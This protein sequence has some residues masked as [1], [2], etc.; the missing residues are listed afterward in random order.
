MFKLN[1]IHA[2]LSTPFNYEGELYRAKIRHNVEKWNRVALAGYVVGGAAGEGASLHDEERALL[3]EEVAGHAAPGRLLIAG[4]GRES[5]RETVRS[6]NRAAELGYG[7]ALIETPL[8][9]PELRE[10]AAAQALY[11][12]AVADQ[13]KIPV[14]VRNRPRETG[15]DLAVETAAALSE[16]PNLAGIVE[17][18][19][20]AGKL[21]RLIAAMRP[22]LAVLTGS[23]ARLEKALRVGAIG[24]VLDYAAAAPFSCVTILEAVMKREYEAAEDWQGRISAAAELVG[25]RYGV[26]GLKYA[27]DYN[28]Y[29]GGPPR[30]PLLPLPRPAQEKVE[31]AFHGLRG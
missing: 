28:G 29:Y 14:L 1:G 7:F 6:T 10:D 12:R 19:P 15:I 2:E 4:S 11:F 5:V 30:L 22:G 26:A 25:P 9:Y 20:D 17:C 3:W 18:S 8:Y 27:M 16:H 31:A 24:G 21:E 13:A 23:T